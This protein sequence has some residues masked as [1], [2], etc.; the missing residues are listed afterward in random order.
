M[1]PEFEALLKERQVGATRTPSSVILLAKLMYA[2]RF[3]IT[4][5]LESLFKEMKQQIQHLKLKEAD[6]AEV[7]EENFALRQQLTH[8]TQRLTA[9]RGSVDEDDD[10]E[11]LLKSRILDGFDEEL[12]SAERS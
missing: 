7:I 9:P 3:N 11:E 12:K 6:Y 8:L 4:T 5:L 2:V 1:E 10:E